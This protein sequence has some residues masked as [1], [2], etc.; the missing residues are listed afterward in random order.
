MI[1][2]I[3]LWVVD[4]NTY[5]ETVFPFSTSTPF[6]F[7]ISPPVKVNEVQTSTSCIGIV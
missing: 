2:F 4:N 7:V 5:T 3:T 1:Y 6:Y